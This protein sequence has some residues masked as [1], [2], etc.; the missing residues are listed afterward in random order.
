MDSKPLE[1]A[2]VVFEP[3]DTSKRGS[4]GVTD[5][6]GKYKLKYNSETMGASEG[7]FKVS[8]TTDE[9]DSSE[10]NQLIKVPAAYNSLTTLVRT[11]KPGENEIN[12]ELDSQAK[13]PPKPKAAVANP[14]NQE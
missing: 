9:S 14:R 5:K 2:T 13:D 8:I 7:E 6:D 1:G 3:T 11:V 10:S 12:F 4:Y